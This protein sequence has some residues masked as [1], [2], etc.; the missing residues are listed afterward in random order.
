MDT[1]EKDLPVYFNQD[2]VFNVPAGAGGGRGGFG[3]GG[4]GRRRWRS[5]RS[6]RRRRTDRRREHALRFRFRLMARSRRCRPDAGDGRR[7]TGAAGRPPRQADAA[8]AVVVERRWQ[9]R[10]RWW[11]E[12]EQPRRQAEAPRP[13]V[14]MQFPAA[15]GDMLLSGTLAGGEALANRALP[16]TCRG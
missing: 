15:A 13:R 16:S 11:P 9:R 2:P 10:R 6:E 4:G 12:A 1:R 7:R 5:R 14:V 8:D 3:G